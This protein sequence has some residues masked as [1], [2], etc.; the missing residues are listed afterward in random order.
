MTDLMSDV[1]AGIRATSPSV[2][3]RELLEELTRHG[4]EEGEMLERYTALRDGLKS[5]L[6]SYLVSMILEDERRHH[7]M[8]D[9]LAH[10]IAWG[11]FGDDA[12]RSSVPTIGYLSVEDPE[13]VALTREMLERERQDHRELRKLR[14][15][16]DDYA[17]TT[18]WRLLVDTMLLDT[19]KHERV[20]RFLLRHVTTPLSG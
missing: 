17:E 7:R 12:E 3:D 4:A 2:S 11:G 19:K 15:E 9:E 1:Q 13:F 16:L 18:A 5:N 20:L 6:A 14:R 8:I 10:T